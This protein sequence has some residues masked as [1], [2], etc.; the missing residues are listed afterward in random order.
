MKA[1]I[2]ERIGIFA[3]VFAMIVL[4]GAVSPAAVASTPDG[5]T[6]ANEGVCDVLHGGCG[7]TAAA[8]ALKSFCRRLSQMI[9]QTREP[10]LQTPVPWNANW[11]I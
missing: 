7:K 8:T 11:S 9:S 3:M 10:E 2:R 5:E 6:P 4:A 1:S